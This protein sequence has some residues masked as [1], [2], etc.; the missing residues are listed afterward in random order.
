[1]LLEFCAKE[2]GGYRYL[3]IDT[4]GKTF[5]SMHLDFISVSVPLVRASDIST[6]LNKCLSNNYKEVH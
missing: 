4:D 6:I 2:T 1:M 3:W 5:K